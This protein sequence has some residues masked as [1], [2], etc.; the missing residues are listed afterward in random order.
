MAHTQ[1]THWFSHLEVALP[2]VG[3][4][5]VLPTSSLNTLDGA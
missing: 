4:V 3:V 2:W 1:H 5:V